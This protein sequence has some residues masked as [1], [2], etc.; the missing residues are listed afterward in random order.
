MGVKGL[1]LI[2][3]WAPAVSEKCY[4]NHVNLLAVRAPGTIREI[5]F[6]CK[7]INPPIIPFLFTSHFKIS[8]DMPHFNIMIL[9]KQY[10]YQS[11][12]LIQCETIMMMGIFCCTLFCSCFNFSKTA[13]LFR[14]IILNVS[15]PVILSKSFHKL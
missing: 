8:A 3:L 9:K 6:R 7:S 10:D 13:S 4:L 14:G 1:F 2:N 12:M 11:I 15:L 5:P